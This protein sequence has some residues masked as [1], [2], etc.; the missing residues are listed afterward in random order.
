MGQPQLNEQVARLLELRQAALLHL[1]GDNPDFVPLTGLAEIEAMGVS[2]DDPLLPDYLEATV[3]MIIG[4]GK[5]V[6]RAQKFLYRLF[7]KRL[8]DED[9]KKFSDFQDILKEAGTQ[10]VSLK[11]LSF[12]QSFATLDHEQVWSDTGAAIEKVKSLVGDAFLNS[13]TLL[14]SVREKGFIPHDDD[15]DIA[16]LLRADNAFDAGREWIEVYH[17][18]QAEKLISKPPRRNYGVFKLKSTT[19]IN[20]DVFPAWIENDRMYVYPHTYGDLAA[21]DVFPLAK[22]AT[23]QLP[24]PNNPEAMLAVNYGEN[25]QTPDPSFT[26]PWGPANKR[27]A[28]FRDVLMADTS[29]WDSKQGTDNGA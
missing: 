3:L 15:V 1:M 22:C 19:G 29:V 27:F 21:S 4:R 9:G 10:G 14:G 5:R 11:G 20:I 26:F 18:L 25:W 23:T 8:I 13:G 12:F 17:T 7:Q 2:G 24:I 16:V 6:P 28:S